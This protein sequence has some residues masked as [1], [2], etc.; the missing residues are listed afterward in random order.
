MLWDV[1][2]CGSFKH[3]RFGGTYRLH[4]RLLVTVNF[5]PSS[6]IF[7]ALILEAIPSPE[8]S[9]L[10]RATR[11]HIP[12][13]GILHSFKRFRSRNSRGVY[14]HIRGLLLILTKCIWIRFIYLGAT[15]NVQWEASGRFR[16]GFLFVLVYYERLLSPKFLSGPS[17]YRT[18]ALWLTGC[19]VDRLVM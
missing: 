14:L 16:A 10:T 4:H 13:D 2:P 9:L 3:R 7:V 12:E 1:T 5:V 8:T 15:R 11:C 18:I 6:P 17:C 19:L